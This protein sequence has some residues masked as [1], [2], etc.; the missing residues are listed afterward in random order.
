[1][2][3]TYTPIASSTVSG[4]STTTVTFSGIPST[5]T[6]LVLVSRLRVTKTAVSNDDVLVTLNGVNTGNLYSATFLYGTGSA[7]GSGRTTNTNT[8]FWLFPPAANATAGIFEINI[9][10][11]MNYANTTT[12]KAGVSNSGSMSDSTAIRSMVYRSNAAISSIALGTSS[13]TVYFVEGSSF[14]L[15]GIKAA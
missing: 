11:L 13:G 3:S 9:L 6:D 10:N 1:M 4:S 12:F 14:S 2:P 7:N 15:Y 8:G 5:Y